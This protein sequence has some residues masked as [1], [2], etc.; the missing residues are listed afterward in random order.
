MTNCKFI[1]TYHNKNCEFS[2][3]LCDHCINH[4]KDIGDCVCNESYG[5]NLKKEYFENNGKKEGVYKEY[6]CDGT[7]YKECNYIDGK[8][9]GICKK[10]G[11]DD[12]E[13]VEDYCDSIYIECN[14]IND[15]KEGVY[16]E[17]RNG[18]LYN[19]WNY[20]NDVKIL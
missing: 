18:T 2:N 6:N 19:E 4:E 7:L 11:Y 16:K 8:L 1:K 20:I 14:Y 9:N 15:K 5:I 3:C 12:D 10:Y 17:Y 13:N